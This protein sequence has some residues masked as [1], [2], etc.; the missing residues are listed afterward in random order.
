MYKNAVMLKPCGSPFQYPYQRGKKLNKQPGF[1]G[2]RRAACR[3]DGGV[4]GFALVEL[5][6]VVLII[7]ILSAVALP[8]YQTAVAKTR[9][10]DLIML[11]RR[12]K[13]AQEVYYM[14]NGRYAT[15]FDELDIGI[16]SGGT[17]SGGTVTYPSSGNVVVMYHFNNRVAG[18]NGCNN[19]EILLEQS[20]EWNGISPGEAFCWA[21]GQSCSQ[22]VGTRVCKSLGGTQIQ[23]GYKI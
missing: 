17:V 7:G 23:G 2:W 12:V 14:A 21:V 18:S 3:N 22:K 19:Y 15:R 13:E 4:K 11:V 20:E 5:L 8:Q 16:P 9:Y 10:M 1:R 6:V